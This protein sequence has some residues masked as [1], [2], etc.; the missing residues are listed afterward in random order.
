L[1]TSFLN[2]A[3]SVYL[4]KRVQADL[5]S[6]AFERF[7]TEMS[8]REI[9]AKPAGHFI[10]LAGDETAR[11]GSIVTSVNQIL[12][13]SLLALAYLTAIVY[14]SAWLGAAVVLFLGIA[15]LSLRGTLRRSQ[16]LS[17][18]QLG[19]AK[20][21]HSVFL[22]ALNGLRSVRALS[23]EAFV[24][25]KYRDIIRRYTMTHFG[26]ETLGFAARLVPALILL[27]C[28]GAVAATGRL[29]VAGPE[30]LAV[31]VTALAFLLRFFPAS[32]QVLGLFMRLLADVRAAADVTHLL[33]RERGAPRAPRHDITKKGVRDIELRQVWFGYKRAQ[34]VLRSFNATFRR[35]RTYALMGPS[36]SGK[37]TIFDLLL[38][39]YAPDSGSILLNGNPIEVADSAELR[40][41]MVLVGQQVAILN[42]T[43]ANNVRF[44]STADIA[45]VER[46]CEAVC[47]DSFINAL[48]QRYDTVLHFQ[49]SNL[50]GGQRQRIAVARA[51]LRNP[52]VLLLDESTTGLD[53]ETRDSV[54][55]NII[56]RYSDRIVIFATHDKDVASCVDEVVSMPSYADSE[57]DSLDA[58]SPAGKK[59][60]A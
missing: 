45:E 36:G 7:V 55:R 13:S 53:A 58:D 4:G 10:T 54:V 9:D 29:S 1:I 26:I 56:A 57:Q 28:V 23:A 60:W 39:F 5:S 47:L 12:G 14:F 24:T 21:A 42:D 20:V 3:T 35:G 27:V 37:T 46:A 16:S 41:H 22:D 18:R 17:T 19:E 25:S 15:F 50:S 59:A 6:R 31:V 52:Q 33:G 44:G 8:L 2:Q 11:A 43:I 32:G 38:A 51:L 48:P 30:Q 49:G 40:K 34:P